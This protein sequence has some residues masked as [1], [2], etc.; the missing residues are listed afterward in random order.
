MK[1][2]LTI[3][4]MAMC[5]LGI[6]AVACAEVSVSGDYE[7]AVLEDG[8]AEI[9]A[10]YG[11][12][13]DL[14]IPETLDGYRVTSIGDSA[15]FFSDDL[16][17]IELP[18]GVKK[19]GWMAFASCGSLRCAKLPDTI[20]QISPSAFSNCEQLTIIAPEG[21]YAQAYCQTSGIRCEAPSAVA[22]ALPDIP[23]ATATPVPNLNA[24]AQNVR[25][26]YRL[27]GYQSFAGNVEFRWDGPDIE[28]K[29]TWRNDEGKLL[30]PDSYHYEDD[31]S[32]YCGL[33]LDHE[34]SGKTYEFFIH[35][36]NE[37]Y[38]GPHSYR[39][40]YTFPLTNVPMTASAKGFQS[41]V[42]VTIELDEDGK[43]ASIVP[44]ISGE[45][46]V[47]ADGCA[48]FPFLEQFIGGAGPFRDVDV[49]AGATVTSNAIIDAVN[50]FYTA[51][52]GTHVMASAKGFA[53]DVIVSAVVKED[54][55]IATLAVD[56]SGEHEAFAGYCTDGRF[57]GQFLG[58]TGAFTD[59][60]IVVGATITSSAI[61]EAMN[62]IA[63]AV[64][65]IA[66][67]YT[68][69]ATSTP[70]P[71][72]V[73]TA[74]PASMQLDVTS[75][76]CYHYQLFRYYCALHGAERERVNMNMLTMMKRNSSN[77]ETDPAADA[78]AKFIV[79]GGSWSNRLTKYSS[80]HEAVN[81]LLPYLDDG[82][83]YWVR[84]WTYVISE[85]PLPE[86][87]NDSESV[88]FG[89]LFSYDGKNWQ[90]KC[91]KTPNASRVE[92][93]ICEENQYHW[94]L[95]YDR[96]SAIGKFGTHQYQLFH[97]T[98]MGYEDG[99][100]ENVTWEEIVN[101]CKE[102]GGHPA[103]ISSE[104]ENTYLFG[105]INS[106]GVTEAYFGLTDRDDEGTFTWVDGT[107]LVYQNW[108]SGEPNGGTSENYGMFYNGF[109]DATWNDGGFPSFGFYFICEWD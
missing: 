95:S 33:V 76:G 89:S 102:R 24:A 55:T 72:P 9:T 52:T 32:Y 51:K 61:L 43:I 82:S 49:V 75:D 15:F 27:T 97:T 53:S 70:A 31:T 10:Y 68:P 18:T 30:S 88:E 101:F 94:R 105:F 36:A 103:V 65:P 22:D 2:L 44:D 99:T 6:G 48:A 38:D 78:L 29:V 16:V 60:D 23:A 66:A 47:V 87:K 80:Y 74:V 39:F 12:A 98:D 91:I 17:T 46:P 81:A 79:A 90:G 59:V 71:T 8:S 54:G 35:P 83:C 14:V 45:T 13:S 7:Y 62:S 37:S 4:F 73:V 1:K 107:N 58:K 20:V 108:H 77:P 56:A 28:W 5:I 104:A 42:A 100:T 25:I 26:D 109:R 69:T 41:D 40:E 63:A 64:E 92:K 85:T 67:A 19:V 3:M 93:Y 86:E 84:V 34:Q 21:S 96:E 11:M 50:S 57:L 106:M